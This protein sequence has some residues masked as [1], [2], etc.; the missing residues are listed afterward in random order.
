MSEDVTGGIRA[1]NNCIFLGKNAGAD[2]A[3]GEGLVII[4]DDIRDLRGSK[5]VLNI[6]NKVFIGK[7]LMG[8]PFNLLD[9]LIEISNDIKAKQAKQAEEAKIDE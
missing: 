7:T 1:I 2:I 8:K 6:G 4:G 3:N 9:V 5:D